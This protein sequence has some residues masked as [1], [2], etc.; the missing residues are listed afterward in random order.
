M[1]TPPT[2]LLADDE[3]HITC[4]M[5]QKLRSAGFAVIS[6]RDGEEALDLAQ[7]VLP[8]AVV[9]DLQMPRMSGL[10]LAIR[11]RETP[12]TATIPV[13]MLT[14]RGYIMDPATTGQTNIRYVIGKPF[15]AKDVLRKV[16]ELIGERPALADREAA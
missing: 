6:A 3:A 11:L 8:A 7:R 5:A 14:A 13:I 12:R 9:T 4:V 10:E 1:T 15:S 16:T 2:I